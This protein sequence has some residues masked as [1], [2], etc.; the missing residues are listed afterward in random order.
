[1][2][3][4]DAQAIFFRVKTISVPNK[5]KSKRENILC[6]PCLHVQVHIYSLY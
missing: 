6:L 1:M 4:S 5:K 2:L 3:Q